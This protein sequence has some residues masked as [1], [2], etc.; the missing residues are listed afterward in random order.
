MRH[1]AE[2]TTLAPRI[3]YLRE[4]SYRSGLAPTAKLKRDRVV[5]CIAYVL[6]ILR[7]KHKL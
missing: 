4:G 3:R 6:S 2:M 1:Y 5:H 7:L